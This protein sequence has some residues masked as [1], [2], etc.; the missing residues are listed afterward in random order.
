M[1]LTHMLQND[2][3]VSSV[4]SLMLH[5]CCKCFTLFGRGRAGGRRTGHRRAGGPTDYG[6][7][8][9]A[10][11]GVLLLGCSSRLL[12]VAHAEKEEGVTGQG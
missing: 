6:Y 4:F 8:I 5:I 12:S 1:C 9:G 10:H 2:P 3:N 7:A 11:W